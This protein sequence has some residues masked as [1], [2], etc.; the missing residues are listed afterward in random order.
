MNQKYRY[1]ILAVLICLLIF[2]VFAIFMLIFQKDEHWVYISL[3]FIILF[4]ICFVLC[5]YAF[6]C[7]YDPMEGLPSIEENKIQAL[8]VTQVM[9]QQAIELE[10]I[11]QLPVLKIK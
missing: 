10:R 4:I 6:V 3:V 5:I 9:V 1:I 8:Q 7:G 2:L 11:Q